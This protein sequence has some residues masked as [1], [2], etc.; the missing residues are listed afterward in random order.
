[1]AIKKQKI[2]AAGEFKQKC[3]ALIDE[4]ANGDFILIVTKHG[5]Q[6]VQITAA[7][8]PK[9]E[10]IFGCMRG[11]VFINDDLTDPILTDW[12]ALRDG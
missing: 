4:V 9:V 2:I 3:L 12:E 8:E 7:I 11:S 10:K 1:M 5:R 6:K